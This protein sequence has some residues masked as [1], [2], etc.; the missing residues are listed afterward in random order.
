MIGGIHIKLS[1]E[2]PMP[3]PDAD[4]CI[5][6]DFRKGEGNP[7]RVFDAASMIIAG[8]EQI[9]DLAADTIDSRIEPLLVLEDI[10]AG[11]IK[12]WM[13]NV[14]NAIDDQ[15]IK[16]LDWRPAVGKYLVKAKYAAITW[17]DSGDGQSPPRLS[18]LSNELREIA[19]ETDVRHLPDYPPIHD[20][21]LLTALD[22]LQDAK[23]QL[24]RGDKM[25]IETED[26]SYEV[27][28]TRTWSPTASITPDAARETHSE[29]EL[30]LTVRK[31]D[32]IGDTQWQFRHG[33]NNISAPIADQ[34]WLDEYHAGNIDLRPGDALR[35]TVRFSY[36]YDGSGKLTGQHIEIL[37]ILEVIKGDGRQISFLDTNN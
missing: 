9:D 15:A 26:R 14:L 3:P 21:R 4:F 6:I 34:D 28:L 22:R 36:E 31:P 10:E 18:D 17:L 11:S 16:G 30:I 7:R 1:G 13:K 33:K 12:V 2:P 19:Q 20:A 23:K 35:C 8:F 5:T 37:K 32:M 24:T 25:I 27:D 29:G